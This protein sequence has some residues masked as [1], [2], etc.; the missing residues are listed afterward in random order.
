MITEKGILRH[1]IDIKS[2]DIRRLINGNLFIVFIWLWEQKNFHCKKKKPNWK[3]L[4][5]AEG[6]M[7]QYLLSSHWRCR[8]CNETASCSLAW[9]LGN[10]CRD[11]C[12]SH[13]W[14]DM[15]LWIQ[16]LHRVVSVDVSS[17]APKSVL[18][19]TATL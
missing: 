15:W 19:I 10:L 6:P 5:C 7:S 12:S 1:T 11:P 8:Q 3:S 13:L 14:A 16:R 18:F 17:S 4:Y 2:I 9:W